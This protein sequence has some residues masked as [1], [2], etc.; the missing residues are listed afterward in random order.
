[1]HRILLFT[2]MTLMGSPDVSAAQKEIDIDHNSLTIHVGKT[3]I[4]AAA[5][6]E[7]TVTAPIKNGNIDDGQPSHVSFSVDASRLVVL[8][9]EHQGDSALDAREGAR[10]CAL[11]RD[12]LCV[13]LSPAKRGG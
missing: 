11:S 2:L 13:R 7:H 3:G 5:G 6:H 8:P 12:Q 1:M 10:E 9:E 4:L